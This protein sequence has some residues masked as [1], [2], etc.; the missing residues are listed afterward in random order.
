MS[1]YPALQKVRDEYLSTP[2]GTNPGR[3]IIYYVYLGQLGEIIRINSNQFSPL[4]PDIDRWVGYLERIRWP[5][6][7]VGH[8]NFPSK[9]D[10]DL[11]DKVYSECKALVKSLENSKQLELMIP[12]V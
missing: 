1:L 12:E 7:V 10:R 5:R 9:K 11:I 8:M 6:N 2:Q 4:I 3:H